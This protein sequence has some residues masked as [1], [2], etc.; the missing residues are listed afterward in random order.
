MSPTSHIDQLVKE[1]G[2]ALK[3][4][5]T[6]SDVKEINV[7][8]LGRKG[9]LPEILKSL[10]EIPADQRKE[11]GAAANQA[12]G[13][14]S[15]LIENFLMTAM[16][17]HVIHCAWHY[18]PPYFSGGKAD[19]G[20]S[21]SVYAVEQRVR[22][23]VKSNRDFPANRVKRTR[24]S[25]LIWHK[26]LN[27]RLVRFADQSWLTQVAFPFGRLLIQD[28]PHQGAETLDFT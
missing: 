5:R 20:L 11:V 28:M 8:Y 7:L 3:K 22:V 27:A 14:L 17:R 23:P 15:A 24:Y 19:P 13:A 12:K 2:S 9:R 18:M 25:E 1:A 21:L 26:T 4:A 10:K 16:R 6:A